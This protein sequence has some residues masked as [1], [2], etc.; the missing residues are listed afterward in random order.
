MLMVS[1]AVRTRSPR[2]DPMP[3]TIAERC[4]RP[5]VIDTPASG[6]RLGVCIRSERGGPEADLVAEFVRRLVVEVPRGCKYTIFREPHLECG[7]PD[8]VVAVWRSCTVEEWVEERADVKPSDLR[9]LQYLVRAKGAADEELQMLYPKGWRAAVDRLADARLIRRWRR[10]WVPRSLSRSFALRRLIAV[11]A[12][13]ADWSGV[14]Q[15]A[16]R[17]TWFAC[18]SYIL[19]PAPAQTERS[20]RRPP[21]GVRVCTPDDAVI[22]VGLAEET[23]PRCYASWLFNEWVLRAEQVEPRSRK[24]R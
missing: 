14:I 21:R 15:Q 16:Q 23:V 6:L 24:T 17:N 20:G 9:V 13:I 8:L 3:A 22:R 18:D 19:V 7:V 11:E 1:A 2:L 12:K 10:M 5:A 4:P